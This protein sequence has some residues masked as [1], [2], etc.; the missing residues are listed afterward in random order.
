MFL[1]NSSE[2]EGKIRKSPVLNDLCKT[3]LTVEDISKALTLTILSR[4]PTTAELQ[5]YN[6]YA[7]KNKLTTKQLCYDLAWLEINSTE[8][9]YNH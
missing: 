9:L 6:S 7:Y 3:Q 8:F 2:L 5:L 1:M 4:Y